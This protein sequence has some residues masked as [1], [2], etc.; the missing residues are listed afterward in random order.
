MNSQHVTGSE[1]LLISTPQYFHY[2]FWSFWKKMR[3]KTSFLEVSEILRLFLTIV[4]PY[5]MYILSVKA[6]VYR[7]QFRSNYLTTKKSFLNFFLHFQN[8]HKIL[9]TFKK[10]VQL[11][12]WF[13]SKIIA[14]KKRSHVNAQKATVSEHLWTVNILKGPK[15]C[16][17]QNGSIFIIFFDHSERKSALEPL[18]WKYL[19]SWDSFLP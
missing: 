11:Q 5:N 10:Q 4:A 16:C 18:F 17:N 1:T 3:S 15:Q 12:R 19:K 7:N 2:I 6:S 8:L 9:K 14:W 13:L